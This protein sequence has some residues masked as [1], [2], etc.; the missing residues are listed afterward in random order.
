VRHRRLSLEGYLRAVRQG[1]VITCSPDRH[2][3]ESRPISGQAARGYR[4]ARRR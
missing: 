3:R 4:Q 2:G 1:G